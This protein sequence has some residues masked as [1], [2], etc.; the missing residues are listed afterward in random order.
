MLFFRCLSRRVDPEVFIKV[1]CGLFITFVANLR[2]VI[3]TFGVEITVFLTHIL[4]RM[5]V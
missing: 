4:L 1:M 2:Y 3:F 5:D